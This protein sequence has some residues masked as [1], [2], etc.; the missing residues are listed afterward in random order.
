MENA[1]TEPLI[2]W[3]WRFYDEGHCD[4]T[5]L[6]VH[7]FTVPLFIGG[8]LA[9]PLAAAL[10]TPWLAVFGLGAM[11]AAIAAQGRGHLRERTGPRPFRGPGDAVVRIF[12]EQ[13]ITFPRFVATG[14]FAHAWRAARAA[15]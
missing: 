11:V 2:A 9:T 15:E 6:L 13:W 1:R 7:L 12:A 5:N 8:T 3:Q 10:R 14:H 4:R